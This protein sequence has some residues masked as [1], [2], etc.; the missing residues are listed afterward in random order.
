MAPESDRII[1]CLAPS[2]TFNLAGLSNIII[3]DEELEEAFAE[4][5]SGITNPLSLAAATA[6]YQDGDEWLD[7]LREHL[8]HNLRLVEETVA[9]RLPH[10]R[11]EMPARPTWPGSTSAITPPASMTSVRSSPARRTCWWRGPSSWPMPSSAFGSMAC[12]TQ[13]VE[14]LDRMISALERR[15]AGAAWRSCGPVRSER[16]VDQPTNNLAGM[17][18]R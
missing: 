7:A 17:S 16:E 4:R 8:D 15:S 5:N 13:V 14:A 10:A 6:V 18:A 9:S 3:P 11:F 2:K 12:P 1:T